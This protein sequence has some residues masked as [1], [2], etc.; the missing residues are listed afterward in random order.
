[1]KPRVPA[2]TFNKLMKV[3]KALRSLSSIYGFEHDTAG[4]GLVRSWTDFHYPKVL[5]FYFYHL[6]Y[7][8]VGLAG[9]VVNIENTLCWLNKPMIKRDDKE[10]ETFK[11]FAK[12]VRLWGQL[13]QLD[14]FQSVGHYAGAIIRVADGKNLSE[15]LEDGS[16]SLDDIESLTPAWESQLVVGT[17]DTDPQSP[18]YGLPVTY[19]YN[20]RGNMKNQQ[21]DGGES[22]TVHHSRVWVMSEGAAGNT[23]YG[24]S[25]LERPYN[26][27]ISWANI[28]G[29]G[30]E[31]FLRSASARMVLQQLANGDQ[32]T[33]PNEDQLN[34]ITEALED[35]Q[36]DP[37]SAV[38]YLG[39]MELKPITA[40]ISD[41]K[42][43][44]EA[45]LNDISAACGYSTKA[46][47]GAQEGVLAGNQDASADRQ[48]AQSR[49]ENYLTN[50][51]L[52][53]LEWID[54]K[55]SDFNADS[56]E[57]EWSDLLAP[58]DKDKFGNME[59][60]MRVNQMAMLSYG[61]PVTTVNEVRELGQYDADESADEL[62][63]FGETDD[64][65]DDLGGDDVPAAQ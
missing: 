42:G 45:A 40:N 38:P 62:D 65:L 36:N 24:T 13:K 25:K 63:D 58:S 12:R 11:Q 7:K 18:R 6:A 14:E 32:F 41:P 53:V 27:L 48:K 39:G 21:R 10:D 5:D 15:P 60:M 59:I 23:I 26:A 1:M 47:I 2:R 28:V 16:I 35:M 33:T 30:G 57:V 9:A 3:N 64:P 61:R 56:L 31:A 4:G 46:L 55:C 54:N 51:M 20:Q 44:T 50:F 22:V 8:R 52:D 29:A 19:T 37:F 43:F 17:L 49:R 34:D